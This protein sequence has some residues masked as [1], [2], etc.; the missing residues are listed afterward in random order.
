MS[1]HE[2]Q[3]NY[4]AII[5]IGVQK[6][7]GDQFVDSESESL[8]GF[9]FMHLHSM[10]I[11]LSDEWPILVPA[12]LLG[13]GDVAMNNTKSTRSSQASGARQLANTQYKYC[14][15]VMD[16]GDRRRVQ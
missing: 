6:G 14:A 16:C 10:F 15:K 8:D 3:I 2:C 4:Q 7:G 1:A 11:H 5:F 12:C 13:S 9:L